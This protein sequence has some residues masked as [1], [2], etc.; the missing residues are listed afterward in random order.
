VSDGIEIH[1]DETRGYLELAC[2]P[3]AFSQYRELARA[4]LVDIPDISFD[5]VIEINVV[6][7]ATFVARRDAPR[8]RIWDWIIIGLLV[9]TIAFAIIGVAAVVLQI[10]T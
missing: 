1:F 5:K 10:A 9:L 2:E 7:T 3:D 8:R 4:Q 6:D